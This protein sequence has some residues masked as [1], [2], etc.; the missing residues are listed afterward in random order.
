MSNQT[1]VKKDRISF[2]QNLNEKLV[3]APSNLTTNAL[4]LGPNSAI[5][6]DGNSNIQTINT[7]AGVTLSNQYIYA[8]GT[9]LSNLPNGIQQ[10]NIDSTIRGL[11]TFGYVS[12]TQLQSTVQG[13]VLQV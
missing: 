8:D 12:S 6:Y 5:S 11:A 3:I 4:F 7:L 1:F 10:S 13:K 2:A 9:Y